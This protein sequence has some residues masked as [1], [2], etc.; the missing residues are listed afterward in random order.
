ML[1]W[2]RRARRITPIFTGSGR[3]P[4]LPPSSR[5]LAECSVGDSRLPG[6]RTR[7]TRYRSQP[8]RDNDHRRRSVP[9]FGSVIVDR[10]PS[11][12]CPFCSLFCATGNTAFSSHSRSLKRPRAF[13][14]S[15]SPALISSLWQRATAAMLCCR[16]SQRH[17]KGS[18]RGFDKIEAHGAEIP[19]S[20]QVPSLI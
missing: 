8:P 2:S 3:S 10:W 15:T 13:P 7:R 16:G 18:S 20:P 4:N 1:F 9:I 5:P 14:A 12:I 19:I 11:S 17:K 6:H